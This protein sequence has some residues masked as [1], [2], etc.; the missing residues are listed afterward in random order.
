MRTSLP[1]GI[2]K[3]PADSVRGLISENPEDVWMPAAK[4][5]ASGQAAGR[6]FADVDWRLSVRCTRLTDPSQL[7]V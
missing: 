4:D 1:A 7:K 3:A 6:G 2:A 5:S